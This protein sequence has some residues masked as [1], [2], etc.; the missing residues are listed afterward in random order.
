MGR[1]PKTI[2]MLRVLNLVE[3]P[4]CQDKVYTLTRQRTQVNIHGN[5]LIT[6]LV[7][8][9]HEGIMILVVCTIIIQG[10]LN[11]AGCGGFTQQRRAEVVARAYFISWI[12]QKQGICT[13]HHTQ[14]RDVCKFFCRSLE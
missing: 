9:G 1:D 7:I 10:E 12:T 6:R 4:Q 3:E 13:W 11:I 2:I 14:Y 8:P 5:R